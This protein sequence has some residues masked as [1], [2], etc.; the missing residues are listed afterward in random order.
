L[1]DY[2]RP[3]PLNVFR[4]PPA[5]YPGDR[6]MLHFM[7][8]GW[9][10]ADNGGL[11]A[12]YRGLPRGR[13]EKLDV[14]SLGLP[15]THW[16]LAAGCGDLNRDGW[17]DLYLASDFGPDDLYLNEHGHGF[18]R[19]AG[20]WYGDVGKDTYKGMNSTFADFD[21]NGWLDVYVSN[22]HHALQA[23]GSL[24]WMT[25]PS[26]DPFVPEFHDE[27]TARG[28]LNENR[29]GWGAAAGDLDLDGWPDL[30]Q[31]N[32][33][34]DDRLDR[35]YKDHKD[36]RYVNHKLMQAGPE[37]HTYADM[38]GDLRGRTLFPNEAR[39][40][41]LNL[42]ARDPGEFVDVARQIG[43]ADPDCSRGVVLADLDND[44]DL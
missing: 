16:T 30:V 41:Y 17:T 18:R 40:A 2:P 34:V 6:R 29:W 36:Y 21:G 3:T 27:A 14:R 25:R 44:G 26:R 22:N 23:E 11:N 7:H 4:L 43:I 20:R 9:H 13:F 42:G 5:E 31:A 15:Q 37:I 19:I 1:P 32:G 28:A 12:L 8:N 39:R 38:W 24:L 10:D 35:R 33:M